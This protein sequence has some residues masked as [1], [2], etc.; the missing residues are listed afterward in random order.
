MRNPKRGRIAYQTRPKAPMPTGWRSEY[1]LPS[2]IQ[3]RTSCRVDGFLPRRD[4]KRRSKDLGAH[5]FGHG[6][7]WDPLRD[8][9]FSSGGVTRGC[10]NTKGNR[11][12]GRDLEIDGCGMGRNRSTSSGQGTWFPTRRASVGR[13]FGW[14][15]RWGDSCKTE[16]SVGSALVSV[17]RG[18]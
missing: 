4:L 10:A 5:E 16:T 9:S 14:C 8:R 3:N 11:D 12:V 6:G 1:L 17:A 18:Q 7:Q 13:V 15:C 2:Q